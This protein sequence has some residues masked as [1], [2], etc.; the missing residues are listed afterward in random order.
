MTYQCNRHRALFWNAAGN[1]LPWIFRPAMLS[2]VMP[3]LRPTVPP[4][5]PKLSIRLSFTK[6]FDHTVPPDQS[7]LR[8][9]ILTCTTPLGS[10]DTSY[11]LASLRDPPE[12]PLTRCVVKFPLLLPSILIWNRKAKT[13]F[14]WVWLGTSF[15]ASSHQESGMRPWHER[16]QRYS[17][18]VWRKPRTFQ[19]LLHKTHR[20]CKVF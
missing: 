13:R 2:V 16:L 7:L 8:F 20:I 5:D 10:D 11:F 4:S 9:V 6:T 1:K 14:R 15:R 19:Q 12:A 3:R 18:L 17:L